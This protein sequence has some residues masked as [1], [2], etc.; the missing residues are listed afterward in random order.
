MGL[1]EMGLGEM[2]GHHGWGES[3]KGILLVCIIA[4]FWGAVEKKF[5]AKM[6]RAP[7]VV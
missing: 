3:G 6:A 7:V 2:G 5:R 1:G 4:V